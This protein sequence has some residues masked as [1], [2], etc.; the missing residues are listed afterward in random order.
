MKSV[1]WYLWDSSANK[2]KLLFKS[3]VW[4]R[5]HCFCCVNQVI[6]VTSAF[7]WQKQRS[8]S[9]KGCDLQ[10][11]CY[12][13]ARLTE[14]TTVKWSVIWTP[15][16]SHCFRVPYIMSP[17]CWRGNLHTDKQTLFKQ[18]IY[19]DY[20]TLFYLF[21]CVWWQGDLATKQS[22]HHH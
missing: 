7:T 21:I 20:F 12:S 4:Y 19:L 22:P 13:K 2:N 1:C 9:K 5:P 11:S 14:Q 17:T 8:V 6:Q 15:T 3:F 18:L 10:P 16:P